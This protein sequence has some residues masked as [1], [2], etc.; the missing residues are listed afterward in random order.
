ME[1]SS[2]TILGRSISNIKKRP[3]P[4]SLVKKEEDAV[5]FLI[6]DGTFFPPFV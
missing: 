3:D 1:H 5:F 2:T 4:G 6:K